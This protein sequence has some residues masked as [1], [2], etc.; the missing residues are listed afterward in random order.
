MQMVSNFTDKSIRALPVPV[1]G[2]KIHYDDKLVGF[3]VRVTAAGYRSF[4]L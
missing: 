3:G 1:K 2:L 4:V